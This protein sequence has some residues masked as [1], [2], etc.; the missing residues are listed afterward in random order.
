MKVL[1]VVLRVLGGC[2][3]GAWVVLKVHGYCAEGS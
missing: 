2:A 3:K 1:K